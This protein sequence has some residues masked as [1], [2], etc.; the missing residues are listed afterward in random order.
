[1]LGWLRAGRRAAARGSAGDSRPSRGQPSDSRGPHGP[2]APPRPVGGARRSPG[3]ACRLPSASIASCLPAG[4]GA[5][6]AVS[7][8]DLASAPGPP[9]SVTIATGPGNAGTPGGLALRLGVRR[10]PS[11]PLGLLPP[12]HPCTPVRPRIHPRPDPARRG[13]VLPAWPGRETRGSALF[14]L[15]LPTTSRWIQLWALPPWP[16]GSTLARSWPGSWTTATSSSSSCGAR[17]PASP[18]PTR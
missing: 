2:P 7:R 13:H 14:Q 5:S 16:R 4:G 1:M 10:R 3:S 17:A 15:R 18:R 6:L 9:F 11:R 12:A 8:T